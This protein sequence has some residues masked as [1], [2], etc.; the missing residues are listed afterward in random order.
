M[1]CAWSPT[2]GSY[3]SS[4]TAKAMVYLSVSFSFLVLF[5]C[6][7]TIFL[8]TGEDLVVLLGW[9]RPISRLWDPRGWYATLFSP[10]GFFLFLLSTRSDELLHG[11]LW[12]HHRALSSTTNVSGELRLR[13]FFFQGGDQYA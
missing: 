3:V 7:T 10:R 5:L 12:V 1:E 13:I 2:L 6:S 9:F 11:I 8:A 4:F